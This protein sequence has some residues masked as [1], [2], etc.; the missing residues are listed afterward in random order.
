MNEEFFPS[1]T[2]NDMTFF[3]FL[4]RQIVDYIKYGEHSDKDKN[5]YTHLTLAV[6]NILRMR[7]HSIVLHIR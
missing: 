1:T 2:T 3:M 6:P 5:P 7:V 4:P